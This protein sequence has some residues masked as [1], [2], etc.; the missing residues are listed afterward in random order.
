MNIREQLIASLNW[1]AVLQA[2]I[3]I[4]IILLLTWLMLRL[5]RL[6]LNRFKQHLTKTAGVP[7]DRTTEE[8]KRSETLVRLLR[9]AINLALLLVAGLMILRELGINIAPIL[10]GAGIL[11]LALGFGA[12]NLVR[13]IISGFFIILENQVRVN[14]VAIINGT[15]GLVERINLRTV[16]LR[17]LG[18]VVHIFPNG[19][20]N[21]LSNLTK[22]WSAY[23]F[24]ISVAYKEE[25]D[26]VVDILK[27]VGEGLRSDE[28]FGSH[29]REDIEI[30]GVDQFAD[31]AVI[32]KGRIITQPIKQ[33]VV[34]REFLRRVKKAFDAE[35]VEIPFPHRSLYFGDASSPFLAKLV[36]TRF[37]IEDTPDEN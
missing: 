35:G 8:C 15:G 10:A 21:T 27:Q 34:G 11:G 32:I 22:E 2:G 13:D 3:R 29:I 9:Q 17:D 4:V 25:T 18:G 26:R 12:Q 14:D 28:E 7:E 23:V 1:T 33:W 24:E 16:V 20:I 31:S 37:G 5:V 30:F 19:G 6:T 36:N